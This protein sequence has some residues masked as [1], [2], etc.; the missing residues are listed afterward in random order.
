M[1]RDSIAWNGHGNGRAWA[2]GWCRLG[3]PW[4]TQ[5]STR[6]RPRPTAATWFGPPKPRLGL[7]PRGSPSSASTATASVPSTCSTSWRR[8]P[9]PR[10]GS[11]CRCRGCTASTTAPR[12]RSSRTG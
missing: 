9:A 4:R 6:S 3:D 8:C 5:R 7:R 1:S 10:P 11:W 12:R 2:T